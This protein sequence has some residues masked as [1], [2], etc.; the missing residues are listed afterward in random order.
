M[1]TGK[2]YGRDAREIFAKIL[3]IIQLK[4]QVKLL[5]DFADLLGTTYGLNPAE[6]LPQFPFL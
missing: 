6:F 1:L 3:Q 2:M 5:S 4:I